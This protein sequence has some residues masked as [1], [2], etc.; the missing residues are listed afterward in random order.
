MGSHGVGLAAVAA[1][2]AAPGNAI[3]VLRSGCNNTGG[4]LT[5][6]SSTFADNRATE[7]G[8]AIANGP[9]ATTTVSGT[10]FLDNAAPGLGGGGA[11]A[12]LGGT[13]TVQSRPRRS[14][15]TPPTPT[16]VPSWPR[17]PA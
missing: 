7:R 12:S 5:V 15:A 14:P 8:G 3:L 1:I 6:A 11:I 16:A 9:G 2:T 13:V 17:P 4:S 10:T